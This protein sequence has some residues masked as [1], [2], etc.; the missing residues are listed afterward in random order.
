[1]LGLIFGRIMIKK[2]P[3]LELEEDTVFDTS[4]D[5]L[6]GWSYWPDFIKLQG[7]FT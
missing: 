7:K 4:L 6:L 3:E 5:D 1:M 2:Y